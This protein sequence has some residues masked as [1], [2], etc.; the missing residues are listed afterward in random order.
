MSVQD[1]NV[2]KLDMHEAKKAS[3]GVEAEVAEPTG[4]QAAVPGGVQQKGEVS[5]PMTQGSGIKPYT[6][7]GMINSMLGA[8]SGM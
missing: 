2:D 4:V 6:K 3:Y 5:G 8:L 7:V 1:T